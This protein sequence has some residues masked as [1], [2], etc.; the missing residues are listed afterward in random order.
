MLYY[1]SEKPMA[2]N[3]YFPLSTTGTSRERRQHSL[4][5]CSCPLKRKDPMELKDMNYLLAIAEEQ[6][7]SKAA[8]RLYMAQSSLSQFLTTCESE[9]GF[10]LFVRTANGVR[11][12]AQGQLMIDYARKTLSEYHLLRDEMQDIAD[13][14]RGS[15]IMGISSFRGSYLV[16]PV[17]NAFHLEYPDIHV[18][19]VEENSIVLEQLLLK[20]EIDLAMIV[21]PAENS[22]IHAEFLIKDEICLITSSTHPVMEFAHPT[23]KPDRTEIPKTIRIEDTAPFEFA[24]NSY[25]TILGRESSKLFNR[26]GIVPNAYNDSLS[27][28]F[29]ASI[30]ASG[31]SLAFTYY[32]SRHYFHNA[33]FLAIDDEF[34][35]IDLGIALPPGRYHSKAAQALRDVFFRILQN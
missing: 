26:H 15:V 12:T 8:V 4:T 14:K 1:V 27:A 7:I 29:S 20:G 10:R 21:L 35:S 31:R 25:D 2:M 9:V 5:I 24:L 19:I 16:P 6:S 30:G 32:T 23:D 13:L 33:E 11:P 22:R 34:L 18:K 17:L 28:L 3:P